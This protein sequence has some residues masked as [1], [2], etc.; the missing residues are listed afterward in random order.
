MMIPEFI[1]TKVD[2][3]IENQE[4]KMNEEKKIINE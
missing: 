3:K 2:E 4:E 1:S